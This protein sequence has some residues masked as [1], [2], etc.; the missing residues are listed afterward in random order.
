MP[1]AFLFHTLVLVRERER[2]R[3]GARETC[4]K[5]IPRVL[6]LFFFVPTLNVS[7]L[8][9]VCACVQVQSHVLLRNAS[10]DLRNGEG[11]L[12]THKTNGKSGI[13]GKVLIRRVD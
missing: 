10:K 8:V 9:L 11:G 7:V 1:I 12:D 6:V 4:R 13:R 2:E 5:S 3:E